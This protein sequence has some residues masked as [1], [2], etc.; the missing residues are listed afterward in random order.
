MGDFKSSCDPHEK[1][2]R[3][4]KWKLHFTF[5]RR[6]NWLAP[7][8]WTFI[9]ATCGFHFS[10]FLLLNPQICI[11]LWLQEVKNTPY[12]IS[13]VCS[14]SWGSHKVITSTT[15]LKNKSMLTFFSSALKR[16]ITLR[17]ISVWKMSGTSWKGFWE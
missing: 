8:A 10:H 11:N 3:L 12:P 17:G 4:V 13:P 15:L 9:S 5:A 1:I 6:E 2:Y 14:F 16:N 7:H